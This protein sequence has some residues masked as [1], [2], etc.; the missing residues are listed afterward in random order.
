MKSVYDVIVA[1]IISEQSMEMIENKKYSFKVAK[2][3]NKAEIKAAVEEIFDGV[4]VKKVNTMNRRGKTVRSG[5]VTSKKADWKKAI[6]T[7]TED[8]KAIEFFE[9]MN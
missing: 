2:N 6:V 3:A 1:P 4:K 5:Y 7:L 9:G 8:S